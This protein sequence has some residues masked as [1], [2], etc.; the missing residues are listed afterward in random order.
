MAQVTSIRAMV[1]EK[2]PS[3]D[4]RRAVRHIV[5]FPS[6]VEHGSSG[7]MTALIADV[8]ETG[9][10]LYARKPDLRIGDEVGLELHLALGG[11]APRLATGRVVRI[12]PLPE[13]RVSLWTHQIGVEFHAPIEL[14]A[15]EIEALLA[16]QIPYTRKCL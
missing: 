12:A 6:T 3:S 15:A 7:K 9:A 2:A 5:C 14:S 1:I 16:R 13:E 10:L 8:A 4:R 11:G